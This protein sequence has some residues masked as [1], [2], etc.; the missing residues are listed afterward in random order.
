MEESSKL[1]RFENWL[2]NV[3][4]FHYKWYFLA[5]LFALSLALSFLIAALTRVHTDWTVVY[6]HEGAAQAETSASLEEL[7]RTRLPDMT[8]RKKV[9]IVLDEIAMAEGQDALR[10]EHGLYYAANDPDIYLILAD[11]EALALY[12]DR[13]GLLDGQEVYDE[14]LGLYL[15]LSD[16]PPTLHS[17]AEEDYA[18]FSEEELREVNDDIVAEHELR[19]DKIR[20][21]LDNWR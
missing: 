11:E 19:V 14:T 18:S 2:T 21:L 20:T 1:H 3:F 12:R 13:L 5:A 10:D 17:N 7:L 9:D 4:W 6:V 8:G 15:L 16:T